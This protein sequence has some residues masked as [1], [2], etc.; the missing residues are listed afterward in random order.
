MP[1]TI[2]LSDD[3]AAQLQTAAN[4]RGR[5]LDSLVEGM[6]EDMLEDIEFDRGFPV[7][8]SSADRSPLNT[9]EADCGF[10]RVRPLRWLRH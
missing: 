6:L 1:I 3:L 8:R 9:Q 4:D 7:V 2:T 10:H 5:T